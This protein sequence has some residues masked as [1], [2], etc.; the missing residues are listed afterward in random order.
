M[1][2]RFTATFLSPP[3]TGASLLC[4]LLLLSCACSENPT[5]AEGGSDLPSGMT[6]HVVGRVLT[7]DSTSA[8]AAEVTLRQSVVTPRG[9]SV[10]ARH[11]LSTDSRGMF[12]F[13]SVA[14]GT[15]TVYCAREPGDAAIRQLIEVRADERRVL[16]DLYLRPTVDITG[17]V[18]L[19]RASKHGPLTILLPG[20]GISTVVSPVGRHVLFVLNDMPQGTYDVA[21]VHADV[22]NFASVRVRADSSHHSVYMRSFEFAVLEVMADTISPL[23]HSTSINS[24]YVTPRSEFTGEEPQWYLA[25]D[26]DGITYFRHRGADTTAIEFP[27]NPG[28]T[29]SLYDTVLTGELV[30]L[31][32]TS[33]LLRAGTGEIYE[34]SGKPLQQLSTESVHVI[35]AVRKERRGE[36]FV[37]VVVGIAP[38]DGRA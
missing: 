35:V 8:A 25:A 1:K 9:D 14:P 33:A 37:Y 24:Y 29:P 10:P 16:E 34:L 36:D 32:E 18:L 28:S 7:S 22:T 20:C 38:Y 30:S 21:F 13:D 3:S 31:D 27:E 19:P 17:H 2:S 15:Y 5:T 12:A 6:A 4:F 11:A 26:F 23:H